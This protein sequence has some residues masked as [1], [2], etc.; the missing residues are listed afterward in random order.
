[1]IQRSSLADLIRSII[2][3]ANKYGYDVQVKGDRHG[4]CGGRGLIVYVDKVKYCGIC[5]RI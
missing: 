3:L 5:G 2:K 1:M 4:V